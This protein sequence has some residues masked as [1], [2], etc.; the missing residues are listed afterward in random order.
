M[1]WG[2]REVP[3]VADPVTF[4]NGV[5]VDRLAYA[6][7]VDVM[8][9]GYVRRHRQLTDLRSAAG[10]VGLGVKVIN[11]NFLCATR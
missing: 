1:E 4:T 7:V 3:P 2:M 10:R 6:D 9:E 11:I 5:A 8:G